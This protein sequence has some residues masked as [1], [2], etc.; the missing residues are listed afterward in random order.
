MKELI[1]CNS[2]KC[3]GCNR[4]IRI[5]P[6]S[7]ANI[8]YIEN[9]KVKVKVDAEKCIACGGCIDICQHGA[10]SFEDDTERFFED[11]KNKVPISLI[12][13]PAQRIEFEDF[14]K[15][16]AWLKKKGV[17]SIYD[18]SIGADLCTWGHVRLLEKNPAASLITQPC[19]AIVNYILKYKPELVGNLSPIH[20]P[21]LCTAIYMKRYC[22]VTER[23]AAISPCIAKSHEFEETRAVQ[24]NVTFDKLQ[25][26]LEKHH[27]ILPEPK[28]AFSF[29]H[30]ESGLGKLFS[31]PGGLKENLEYYI[32]KKIRIDQSEG[33]ET[34][35]KNL[36][37]YALENPENLPGVFD[38]LNCESGCNKG[39]ACRNNLSLFCAN[40]KMDEV[41]KDT[42]DHENNDRE[43]TDREVTDHENVDEGVIDNMTTLF[44]QFDETLRL[45]DFIRKYPDRSIPEIE[46]TGRAIEDAYAALDKTEEQEKNHNCYACGSYTCHEMA[47]RI[48]KG[49]NIPENCIQKARHSVIREHQ[50]FLIENEKNMETVH[51]ISEEV[52]QVKVL[53]D[54]M[55]LSVKEIDTAIEKYSTMNKLIQSFSRQINLLSLNAAIEAA[56]VGNA[57]SGFGIVVQEIR[58]L[59]QDSQE[60]VREIEETGHFAEQSVRRINQS[61][62]EVQESLAKTFDYFTSIAH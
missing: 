19:P 29:D 42:T 25:G 43:E 24:Y 14:D 54:H 51:K 21:M 39:T 52:A 26:Y 27:V 32:G 13:A 30:M 22:N 10:R 9:G 7:E 1:K 45:Q 4:C 38:V 6:V 57:G 15:I 60:A 40:K 28:E 18:V 8:A 16:L 20:S 3:D 61:S 46:V 37:R 23:I 2:E 48:A 58:K 44:H 31:M 62:E 56:R 33:R 17:L 47:I 50:A 12:V 55:A 34:V 5:C 49:I 11:L 41:R 36:D 59:A 53:S 35:Y